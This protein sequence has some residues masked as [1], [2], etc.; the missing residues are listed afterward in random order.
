MTIFDLS[1]F[2]MQFKLVFHEFW[3]IYDFFILE[4]NL[5]AL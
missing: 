5:E 2:E 3:Y 1:T 4:R